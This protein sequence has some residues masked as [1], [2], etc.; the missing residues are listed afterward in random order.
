MDL[1]IRCDRLSLYLKIYTT[2][3]KS[4]VRHWID[5]HNR[6]LVMERLFPCTVVLNASFSTH[7]NV[8][9]LYCIVPHNAVAEFRLLISNSNVFTKFASRKEFLNL[10]SRFTR[11]RGWTGRLI[12]KALLGWLSWR[13]SENRTSPSK[14]RRAARQRPS[15]I[16]IRRPLAIVMGHVPE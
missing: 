6:S 15:W 12:V 10:N 8:S 2:K 5:Q 1:S 11:G 14:W 13:S 7:I 3:M 16:R 9:L 4:W